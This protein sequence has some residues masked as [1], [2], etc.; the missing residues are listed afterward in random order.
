MNPQLGV[1][2][3]FSDGVIREHGTGKLTIVGSFEAFNAVAFPFQAP[4]FL[5]T[6]LLEGLPVNEQVEARV[7][8]E[9]QDKLK[10][11]DITGQLRVDDALYDG[12]RIE[13]PLPFPPITFQN[14]GSY[15]LKVFI[16]GQNVGQRA[17]AVRPVSQARFQN[18]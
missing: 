14:P 17:V 11:A 8:L 5:V 4:P 9:S 16:N 2:I 12:G 6:L 18:N 10:L 7:T 1:G 15:A 3:I 13:L